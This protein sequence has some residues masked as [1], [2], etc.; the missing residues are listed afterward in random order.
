MLERV[1]K[2]R[3]QELGRRGGLRGGAV[4]AKVL[5]AARKAEIARGAAKERWKPSVLVLSQPKD[6]G[7]LQCFVAQYGNGYALADDTCDPSA[8]LLRSISACRHDGGLAR[9]LPVFVWR[10]RREISAQPRRLLAVSPEEA[11]AL[12]YF[13]EL[14]GRLGG[15]VLVSG[16]LRDLRRKAARVE[17]PIVFFHLMDRSMLREFAKERTSA[18]ARS[19]NLVLGESDESFRSYF[20]RVFKELPHAAL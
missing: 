11:C 4:R 6:H 7:E 17:D 14:T 5:S 10:A 19:W 16:V 9:M 8:V 18:L 15:A 1:K 20:T 2:D 13:L 3:M 12:G